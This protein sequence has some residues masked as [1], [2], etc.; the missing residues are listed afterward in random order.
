MFCT[1]SFTVKG[2]WS[3]LPWALQEVPWRAVIGVL[4][5][6][7]Q[8]AERAQLTVSEI[9]IPGQS[10]LVLHNRTDPYELTS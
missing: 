7:M 1:V 5:Q 6:R 9:I 2:H 4:P 3:V 10:K 8:S